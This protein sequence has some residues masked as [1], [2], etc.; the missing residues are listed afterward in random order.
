MRHSLFRSVSVGSPVESPS[1]FCVAR[2]VHHENTGR[3]YVTCSKHVGGGGARDLIA[4]R[5]CRSTLYVN[6]SYR[7]SLSHYLL[8]SLLSSLITILPPHSLPLPLPRF[9]PSPV[10]FVLFRIMHSFYTTHARPFLKYTNRSKQT[11]HGNST[12][13][14]HPHPP[15]KARE[16]ESESV[17]S[18]R[19]LV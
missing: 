15:R 6:V 13:I 5:V 12:P 1:R 19:S 9:H 10:F 11:R 17:G 2:R 8:S 4:A 14:P 16:D 18:Y 7:T 3:T